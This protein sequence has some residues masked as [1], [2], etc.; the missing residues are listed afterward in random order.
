M[1]HPHRV[2]HAVMAGAGWYT[3][4]DPERRYPYGI[5]RTRDLP[6]VRF[7]PE[8]FLRVPMTVMIGDQDLSGEHMR[9]NRRLEEQQGET[10]LE[11]AVSWVAAMRAAAQARHIEPKVALDVIPGGDHVFATLMQTRGLGDRT[12]AAMFGPLPQAASGNGRG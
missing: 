11:R 4:P 1:A 10:R 8:E 5:R 6:D 3:F 2:A 7:D 12:F 9:S